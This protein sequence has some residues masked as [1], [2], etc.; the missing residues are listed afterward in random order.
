M[1]EHVDADPAE[2]AR[3]EGETGS[4]VGTLDRLNVRPRGLRSFDVDVAKGE[5][6]SI[7]GT[8]IIDPKE[9]FWPLQTMP[10]QLGIVASRLFGALSLSGSRPRK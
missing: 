6:T 10:R 3:L 9:P 5:T 1:G 2:V 4:M 8:G 7:P